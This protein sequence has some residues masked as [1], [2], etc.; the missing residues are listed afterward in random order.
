[1][2]SLSRKDPHQCPLCGYAAVRSKLKDHLTPEINL[3]GQIN[4][5]LS[6]EMMR[7]CPMLPNFKKSK[8]HQVRKEKITRRN[9]QPGQK[10]TPET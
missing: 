5:F 3:C 1:M 6:T 10:E 8:S 4:L 9:G 2:P 7:R